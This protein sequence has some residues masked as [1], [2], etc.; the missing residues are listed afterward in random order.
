MAFGM[1]IWFQSFNGEQRASSEN[2]FDLLFING[3]LKN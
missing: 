1:K 2:D 3:D